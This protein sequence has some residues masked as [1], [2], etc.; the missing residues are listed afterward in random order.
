MKDNIYGKI[1]LP[2]SVDITDPC[3]LKHFFGRLN[4][5]EIPAG[6]YDC[7]ARLADNTETEGFGER[8]AVCGVRKPGSKPVTKAKVGRI[9]VDGAMAGFFG[10]DNYTVFEKYIKPG[11]I[12]VK[13]V[14]IGDAYF[15]TSS[16]IG[17]GVYDVY[18][19]YDKD[20]NQIGLRIEFL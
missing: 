2:S 11:S 6:E 12:S 10:C 17:D 20:G 4:D 18:R 1:T 16:G 5:V 19:E 13:D 3:Y 9:G 8:I 15:C 14:F 7:Y